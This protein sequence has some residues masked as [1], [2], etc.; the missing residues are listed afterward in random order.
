MTATALREII[1]GWDLEEGPLVERLD[2]EL[3]ARAYRYSEQAHEGQ[4]R[5]SGD[6]YVS[7]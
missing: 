7:H 1:P 4:K 6:N 2:G 3:L 5:S